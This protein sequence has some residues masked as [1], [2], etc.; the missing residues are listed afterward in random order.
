MCQPAAACGAVRDHPR[1]HVTVS[2]GLHEYTTGSVA[3]RAPLLGLG[4]GQSWVLNEH[5][6]I[7]W[8]L[9]GRR[10]SGYDKPRYR[11]DIDV[12][13]RTFH[14]AEYL[15]VLAVTLGGLF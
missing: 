1:T 2:A 9:T 3:E 7:G 11:P 14:E 15:G 4:I 8:A 12:T 10:V 5:L 6:D 13:G